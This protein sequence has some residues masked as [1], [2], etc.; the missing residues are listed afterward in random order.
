MVGVVFVVMAASSAPSALYGLYQERWHIDTAASTAIYAC[1]AVGAVLTLLFA[2]SVSESIGSKRVIVLSL[3]V[4][5]L[6]FL[7]FVL[8]PGPWWLGLARLIQ[9]AGVGLLTSSAGTALASLHR[10][11]SRKGAAAVNSAATSMGIALGAVFSGLAVEHAPAPLLVPFLVLAVLSLGGMVAVAA[12]PAWETTVTHAARPWRP[13]IIRLKPGSRPMLLQIAPLVTASWAV[14]GL[15]LAL[16][17]E[18]TSTLL[19]T[20]DRATSALVILVVQ[21]SGGLAPALLRRMS[22]R[23]ASV[24]GCI[25]L[26]S[27]LALSVE[28]YG[29]TQA[30]LFFGGA[31]ITGAGFGLCFM[32]SMSTV[33]A[34][35][36]ALQDTAVLPGFFVTAYVAVSLPV[37]A[38]GIVASHLGVE[39]AFAWFGL[40]ISL[41]AMAAAVIALRTVEPRTTYQPVST[42]SCRAYEEQ[43][44]ADRLELAHDGTGHC[45]PPADRPA[46]TFRLGRPRRPAAA[47]RSAHRSKVNRSIP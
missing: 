12:I 26:I 4:L 27:G 39:P 32:G 44:L 21:G 47:R 10:A 24:T 14:V 42:R 29:S 5:G 1:Y 41:I 17:V 18:M 23:S 40:L 45:G 31:A 7:V 37:V 22:D 43:S 30:A 13:R 36:R 2:G 6:S 35:A 46:G 11:R 20:H 25:L 9:G 33:T 15:Y 16:G 19:H 28:G 3:A 34:A 38:L 8:A